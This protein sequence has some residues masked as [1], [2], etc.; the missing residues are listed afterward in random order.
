METCSF[1]KT[2]S[3]ARTVRWRSSDVAFSWTYCTGFELGRGAYV[4]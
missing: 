3:L 1:D 2:S 4:V